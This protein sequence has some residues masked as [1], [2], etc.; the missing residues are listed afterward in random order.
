MQGFLGRT[1]YGNTISKWLIALA[2]VVGGVI[3]AKV[4]YWFV[5]NFVKKITKKTATKLDDILID[6]LEEPIAFAII[7]F[8]LWYGIAYLDFPN[9]KIMNVVGHIYF[10][11]ICF[12]IAWLITRL[13]DAL[14]EEYLVPIVNKTEGDFDDQVLPLLRKFIKVLIW[15]LAI[16]IG[17]N[18]AGYDVGA[19][20]AGLGIGGLAFAM[21]AKDSVANL[22]GGLTIFIDKPFKL[23]DRIK[24][25]GFDG[26]VEEIGIRTTR[27]RTLAGRQVTI[28]NSKF[29]SNCIENISSEPSR[30]VS[31]SLGLTY[32]TDADKIQKSMELLREVVEEMQE[33]LEKNTT[34]WFDAFDDSSLTVKFIYYIKKGADIM[35]AQSDVNILIL[36]KYTEHGLDFAYP[37]RTIFNKNI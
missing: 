36:K 37:T 21:A 14:I 20:I 11:L 6:M 1:F 24:I 26:V 3:L 10:F 17:L 22:F 33:V 2:I 15:V 9:P 28:P 16:I 25:E 34:I 5:G 29:A 18:N 19:L 30:K 31:M 27:L 32:D 4:L 8:G 13:F 12:N 7:I 23:K 35:Q